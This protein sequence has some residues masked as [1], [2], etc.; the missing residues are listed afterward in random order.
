[1]AKK[2]RISLAIRNDTAGPA[3]RTRQSVA[4]HRSNVESTPAA[5]AYLVS[6]IALINPGQP[7]VYRAVSLCT[8]ACARGSRKTTA[9]K[10][11][12]P[13]IYYSWRR[14]CDY[15]TVPSDSLTPRQC[16]LEQSANDASRILVSSPDAIRIDGICC[17]CIAKGKRE[18]ST[19][20]TF[21]TKK[22]S[23]I[24]YVNIASS[25]KQ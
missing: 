14:G 8:I 23:R 11:N 2:S 16:R 13:L 25:S 21:A 7:C 4:K 6:D 19:S 10:A 15:S 9:V 12:V 3:S 24:N 22:Y 1:M 20:Y 18:D 17:D 5:S